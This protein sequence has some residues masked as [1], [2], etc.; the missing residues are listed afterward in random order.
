[1]VEMNLQEYSGDNEFMKIETYLYFD[2]PLGL[3]S[4]ITSFRVNEVIL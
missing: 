3:C 1:M 4:L 2:L